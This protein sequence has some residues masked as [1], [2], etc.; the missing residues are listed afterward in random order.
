MKSRTQ[1]AKR[2]DPHAAVCEADA[3]RATLESVVE[4]NADAI[5]VVGHD[6]QIHYVNA[7]A[8]ALFGRPREDLVGG[9]FGLP[10]VPS[11]TAEI[12]VVRPD[13]CELVAEMRAVEMHWLGAP[14]FVVSLRDISNRKL[15][16]AELRQAHKMEALGNLAGGVAHEFNNLLTA[17][18]FC[19][20]TLIDELPQQDGRRRYAAQIRAVANRAAALTS[21]LLTFSRKRT[22]KP[23]LIDL[24]DVVTNMAAMLSQI[25]GRR[26][27]LVTNTRGRSAMVL[28]DRGQIEQVI[29]NLAVNARDA[30]PE[31]GTL[32]YTVESVDADSAFH[33][34]EASVTLTVRDTGC[35]MPPDV[36][37]RAFEP[38]F[39]TKAEGHGTGL[40]LSTVHGIIHQAGGR[41]V[42]RSEVGEGTAVSVQLPYKD[43][44]ETGLTG[45]RINAA[46]KDAPHIL[47]VDDN[48]DV[49]AV[50]E[51]LLRSQGYR[52]RPACDGSEAIQL[53]HRLDHAFDLI[54]T[55]V[56]MPG[57]GGRQLADDA[58]QLAPE[59]PIVFV[60][61]HVRDGLPEC[62]RDDERTA[63]LGK[64]FS[65]SKFLNT[66]AALVAQ[67]RAQDASRREAVAL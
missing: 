66:I 14:A 7:A 30:M 20:G 45:P 18:L 6:Q 22:V 65:P 52:V 12:N 43:S 17:I 48:D 41:I 10:L 63:F 27:Q 13:G 26:I 67:D 36:Q 8:E 50:M 62:Y 49:R 59:I 16:E 34:A 23:A 38:F 47:V 4:S 11:E 33:G 39:T 37:S 61:G 64:P 44:L 29:I 55:D 15:L 28:I 46:T 21:Q 1:D 9:P 51:D 53:F 24:N 2:T 42:L 35:G 40:G 58:R 56:V 60:S 31:G 25:I 32:E 57:G 54:V 3:T 5:V 19:S